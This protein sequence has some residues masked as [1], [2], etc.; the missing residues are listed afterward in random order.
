MNCLFHPAFVLLVVRELGDDR[1]LRMEG[2]LV[3][4]SSPILDQ[5]RKLSSGSWVL[6]KV[7][8]PVRTG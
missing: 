8:Q 1:I 4:A 3:I 2:T 7:P 6:L 5:L